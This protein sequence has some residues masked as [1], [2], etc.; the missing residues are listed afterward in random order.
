MSCPQIWN[1][2]KKQSGW[3]ASGSQREKEQQRARTEDKELF[4]T[5]KKKKQHEIFLAENPSSHQGESEQQQV[6]HFLHNQN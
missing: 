5:T 3:Q 2:E 4:D 1:I 6:R